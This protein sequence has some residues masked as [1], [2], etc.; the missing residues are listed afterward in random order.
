[1]RGLGDG[2][3]RALW[4]CSTN[5]FAIYRLVTGTSA[6]NI[7]FA[8]SLRRDEHFLEGWQS[9]GEAVSCDSLKIHFHLPLH[10][11]LPF[12]FRWPPFNLDNLCHLE[13]ASYDLERLVVFFPP[14]GLASPCGVTFQPILSSDLASSLTPY[15]NEAL[16]LVLYAFTFFVVIFFRETLRFPRRMRIGLPL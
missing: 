9:N 8:C 1:M 5:Q 4:H 3:H 2:W 11:S 12:N 14:L 15:I 16:T 6:R 7:L 10:L 13:A